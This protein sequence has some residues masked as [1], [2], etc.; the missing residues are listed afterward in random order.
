M[1][2]ADAHLEFQF[3]NNT[4]L[5]QSLIVKSQQNRI[6]LVARP[7]ILGVLHLKLAKHFEEDVRIRLG[8]DCLCSG[9]GFRGK[10]LSVPHFYDG[11]KISV[12]LVVGG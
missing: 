8:V 5:Y 12:H 2:T 6:E 7:V 10:P 3:V 9:L 11:T 4:P 1:K